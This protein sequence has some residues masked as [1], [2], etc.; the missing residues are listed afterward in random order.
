MTSEWTC[1]VRAAGATDPQEAPI[2]INDDEPLHTGD[3]E[4][5]DLLCGVLTFLQELEGE[6]APTGDQLADDIGSAIDSCE[7]LHVLLEQ[8]VRRER[9]N[10][11]LGSPTP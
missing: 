3:D 1:R 4:R 7:K 6:D 5:M 2:M 8:T 10:E 9:H 11:P